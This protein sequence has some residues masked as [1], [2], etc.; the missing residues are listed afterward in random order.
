MLFFDIFLSGSQ[1]KI[2]MSQKKQTFNVLFWIRKG[3]TNEKMSPLSCRVTISG[4]RYEIPTKLHLRSESWSAVAQKSLGKTAN[5]KEVNRYIEDLKITIEDTIAKIRQKSYPLNIENFKLMFQT[6]DNEFST[7]ST[8]FDYH[9][10]M[11][12]KNLR[13]S[14]FI[15]YH[16]TK[17]HLLNFIR[18]KYHVSDYDLA[19]VDKAFVY[20]F[21]AYLQGYRREGDTVCAVNGALKHIQRF[22]KVMNVALQ[23][24]WISRNP[25]C[26]LNAKKT[27]VERGFLSE[28]ELK[29]LEEVPL[30][31][32][33]SIVRDVFIFAVYTGLSYVDIENLTNENINVGIDKSLW[34]HYKRVKT[35]V[36]VSLPLLEPA[37][38]IINR[39]DTYHKGGKKN[40][41]LFPYVSNQ[42]MNRYLKKVA[43]LAG[44]EDRVTYHVARHTFA[45][46]ITLQH[47]IPLE[48]VS[49]M[50]GHTKI[51]TTQVYARVV[52]TKVM[53]DMATLKDMYSHKEDK[54]PNNKAAN[55]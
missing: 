9:E 47:E 25:V 10:I 12:K 5:D 3:R 23:N 21:Y 18:I 52:D 8:L 24:E 30:P 37:L 15:D 22:K 45:T 7:I 51:T 48:T 29:S 33:L 13:T 39:Y 41:P 32:N 4:Q 19:A 2:T 1:K 50:L 38:E 42:I 16:V 28:K 6:Q 34:L 43:K 31:A 17:K 26:L 40:Q 20:E 55:E 46:T 35:G 27:K 49:K 53:R 54:S 36:R 14:T 11:E 44:V